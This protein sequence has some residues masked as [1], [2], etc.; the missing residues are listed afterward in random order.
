MKEL[1]NRSISD[2]ELDSLIRE[3]LFAVDDRGFRTMLVGFRDTHLSRRRVYDAMSRVY[4]A[5]DYTEHDPQV[6]RLHEWL[7]H[8]AGGPGIPVDPIWNGRLHDDAT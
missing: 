6:T 8:V 7:E 4:A 2:S 1:P 5:L 3:R